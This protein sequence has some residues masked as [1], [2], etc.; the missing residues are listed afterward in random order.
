MR[1]RSSKLPKSQ[2]WGVLL[3]L[4]VLGGF[5]CTAD[6]DD[7]VDSGVT[8]QRLEDLDEDRAWTLF[9]WYL[10]QGMAPCDPPPDPWHPF[11]KYGYCSADDGIEHEVVPNAS[12]D[13]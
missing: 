13:E 12:Y 10:T 9:Q 4:L 6:T 1:P 7:E 3:L 8:L 11:V 2:G 5:A